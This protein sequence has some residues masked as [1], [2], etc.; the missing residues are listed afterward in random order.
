MSYGVEPDAKGLIHL[1]VIIEVI[2]EPYINLVKY[3]APQNVILNIPEQA[4]AMLQ[5]DAVETDRD[6]VMKPMAPHN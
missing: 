3:G 1:F 5:T 6:F 2:Q 4:L